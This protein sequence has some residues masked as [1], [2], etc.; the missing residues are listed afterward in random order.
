MGWRRACMQGCAHLKCYCCGSWAALA[1]SVGSAVVGEQTQSCDVMSRWAGNGRGTLHC[2]SCAHPGGAMHAAG[3]RRASTNV[4]C[5]R[6]QTCPTP[7]RN[8]VPGLATHRAGRCAPAAKVG[9]NE[10]Q[11]RSDAILVTSELLEPSVQSCNG[12]SGTIECRE[13]YFEGWPEDLAIKRH[14]EPQKHEFMGGW[15]GKIDPSKGP[16]P[17]FFG[18]NL[19]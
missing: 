1:A 5:Q 17:Q 19:R 3:E 15:K 2:R 13:N 18:D 9:E 10:G 11:G 8:P 7:P 14:Q 16:P 4:L 12:Q 6:E